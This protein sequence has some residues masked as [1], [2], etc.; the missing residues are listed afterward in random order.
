[1]RRY[2]RELEEAGIDTQRVSPV[3]LPDYGNP[4]VKKRQWTT[5]YVGTMR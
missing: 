2:H 5:T 4:E 3:V 1:V